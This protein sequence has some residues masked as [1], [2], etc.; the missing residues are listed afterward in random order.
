MWTDHRGGS[1]IFERG[2]GV[3][4]RST[5]KKGEGGPR[6]GPTLGPMLKS[7]HRGPKGGRTPCPPPHWIRYW[8]ST[9]LDVISRVSRVPGG[10]RGSHQ[11][12]VYH[13]LRPLGGGGNQQLHIFSNN[14]WSEKC[15]N[16]SPKA[17]LLLS[18]PQTIISSSTLPELPIQ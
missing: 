14:T 18:T 7:L 2:G 16:L 5:S 12:A 3:H 13:H 1:R 15:C 17:H 6:G 4:L 8:I 9:S 11:R 10:C